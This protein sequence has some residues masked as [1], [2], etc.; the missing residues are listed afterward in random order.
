MSSRLRTGTR[1]GMGFFAF[2]DIITSVTGVL[3]LVTLILASHLEIASDTSAESAPEDLQRRLSQL[4]DEQTRLE[5]ESRALTESLNAA[6]SQP[7]AAKLQDDIA[8]LKTRIEDEQRNL[9]ALKSQ[10]ETQRQQTRRRDATLGLTGLVDE[11]EKIRAEAAALA[12]KDRVARAEKDGLEQQLKRAE[13]ALL[14]AKSQKGQLWLIPD[15]KATTKEPILAVVARDGVTLERFDKTESRRALSASSASEF[16]RFL[17]EH[18]ANNQYVVFYLRPSGVS[19]FN[20]L[21]EQAKAAQFEIG[22]DALDESTAIHFTR[23]PSL[24]E[25]PN[26][27]PVTPPGKSAPSPAPATT[28][29]DPAPPAKPIATNA[30]TPASPPASPATPKLSWWQRLLRAIGLY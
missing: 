10:G 20:R 28:V 4:L 22:F 13:T 2:Q 18:N 26:E 6:Q 27:T 19:L 9:T 30:P 1:P 3:I 16:S 25:S 12:A 5:L 15:D 17:A 29:S 24:D 8:G 7:D 14:K 23:P 11:A 21:S